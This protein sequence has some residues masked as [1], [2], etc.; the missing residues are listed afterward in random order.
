[1]EVSNYNTD[2]YAWCMQQAKFLENGEYKNL[3]LEN[4]KE[5]IES[6]GRKEINELKNRLI[7]LIFH[8]L[9]WQF[10][11][12]RQGNSWKNTIKEQRRQI[13]F[14]LKD[15]PSLKSKIDSILDEVWK[16][17]VV[18]ASDE[19]N[20]PKDAFPNKPIWT[21]K[22]ILDDDFYPNNDLSN[23]ET[24]LETILKIKRQK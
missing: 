5:E 13:Q 22:E 3:D 23:E 12:E 4:L 14:T 19:T 24:L 9:K 17:A 21:L 15:S 11:V 16:Y 8:L 10:Q 6:M 20:L 18:D 2:F 1:M 7:V